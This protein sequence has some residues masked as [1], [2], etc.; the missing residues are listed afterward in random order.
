MPAPQVLAGPALVA[1]LSAKM[2]D[3][4]KGAE[5]EVHPQLSKLM[6]LAVPSDFLVQ[7][8]AYSETPPH[9][10]YQPRGTAVVRKAFEYKS[11]NVV[12]YDWSLEIGW[13]RNDRVDM[14]VSNLY[15]DA[16]EGGKNFRLLPE[17]AAMQILTAAADPDL[18]PGIPL[19]PDGLAIF[20]A[21][22]FGIADG[23]ILAGGGVGSGAAIRND[24][25][26]ALA[27]MGQFLTPSGQPIY[28]GGMADRGSL[29]IF[30][31]K[32]YP[33]FNEAFYPTLVQGFNAGVSNP[34]LA[35]GVRPPDL[36][37]TA[38][39]TTNTWFVVSY[40]GQPPLFQQVRE[41]M[42]MMYATE[43]NSDEARH[44]KDEYV[45]WTERDGYGARV[46]KNIME[47]TN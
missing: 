20:A 15:A 7:P 14:H 24:W 37:A 46:P 44:T 21:A 4:W 11:F 38:R 41:A 10:R 6:E 19:G 1:G 34:A 22:R 17:R 12:N 5:T 26:K 43:E 29:V 42:R 31:V 40:V 9:P 32:N 33:L 30:N 45:S 23:N 25:F 47:I 13:H 27:Q 28:R 35:G 39:I 36:W 18:L 16:G 3:M 8:Y 2:A